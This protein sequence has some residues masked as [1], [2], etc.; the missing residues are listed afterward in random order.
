MTAAGCGEP[1]EPVASPDTAVVM[2]Y[3]CTHASHN[4]RACTR[5]DGLGEVTAIYRHWEGRWRRLGVAAPAK[6]GWWRRVVAS[7]DGTTLLVQ[8]SGECESQSTYLVSSR[9][10][11][12]RPIFR[13]HN[14]TIAGWTH[15]G[16]ARVRLSDAIWHKNAVVYGPGVYLVNPKTL[17]VLRQREK[18]ARPGC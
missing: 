12:P 11:R 4:F 10:G 17:K 8:W 16:L 15:P 1:A 7:P 18:P 13:R 9:G 3:R 5:F 6:V 2:P 14:S